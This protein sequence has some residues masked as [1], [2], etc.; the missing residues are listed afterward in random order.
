MTLQIHANPGIVHK[1]T[2]NPHSSS[3]ST[4]VQHL[5]L[6]YDSQAA[7]LRPTWHNSLILYSKCD[8]SQRI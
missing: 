7:R 8:T 4:E 5:Y 3:H 6:V 2:E 1:T